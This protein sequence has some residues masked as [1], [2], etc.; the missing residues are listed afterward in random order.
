[1]DTIPEKYI[2]QYIIKKTRKKTPTWN[3]VNEL[4]G[5]FMKK[6]NNDS[7]ERE[8]NFEFAFQRIRD[9]RK[10]IGV[11][12]SFVHPDYPSII[13]IGYSLCNLSAKDRFNHQVIN[14]PPR[15]YVP[16][17]GFGEHIAFGRAA[18]WS[19][20][21][22]IVNQS[23]PVPSSIKSQFRAFI[24]RSHKYYKDKKLPVWAGMFL[25]LN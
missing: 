1:M 20:P 5:A 24:L 15:A 17:E 10:R 23:Y 9:A 18:E 13:A 11:M 12:V 21:E 19:T 3:D 22:L 8:A 14:L 2:K 7:A 4:R 16:A 25:E 6:H